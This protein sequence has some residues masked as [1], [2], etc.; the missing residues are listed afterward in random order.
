M[1]RARTDAPLT[2]VMDAVADTVLDRLVVPGF[3]R[4]GLAARRRLPGWPADPAPDALRG[5]AIAVTGATSGLGAATTGQLLELGASVHLVVR[6]VAKGQRMVTA[7]AEQGTPPDRLR[8]WPCDVSDLTSVAACAD[9][10]LAAGIT[11]DGLVH[12]AGALPAARQSSAQGHELTVALHVLGPVAMTERLLPALTGARVLLVTSGGMYTQGLHLDD[13][14]YER[15]TFSGATA[16]A[17]SKRMQVEL[18]PVLA[19]RW[20]GVRVCAVHPGWAAT[21]GVRRS[22]P[23][24]ARVTGPILRTPAEGADTTTWL[25]ATD[26]APPTGGLWHDRR[27]RPTTVLPGTRSTDAERDRLWRWV[28]DQVGIAA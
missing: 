12:N 1:R 13:P 19:R 23:G 6:D 15:G 7:L 4:I 9:A 24:F 2:R 18:L 22:L 21:P 8:V 16:Y 20:P 11:L 5:T 26:P 25:L 10:L 28:A 17:R 27:L 14:D 3:S